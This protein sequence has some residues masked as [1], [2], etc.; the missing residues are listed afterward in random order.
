[1]ERGAFGHELLACGIICGPSEPFP[2]A[3][4]IE[5]P[6]V[7]TT[8]TWPGQNNEFKLSGFNS[9][10]RIALKFFPSW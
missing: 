3:S 1:M 7:A 9:H 2:T 10:F 6:K 5:A 4:E 8:C